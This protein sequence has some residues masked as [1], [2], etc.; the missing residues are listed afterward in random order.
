MD[1][2]QEQSRGALGSDCHGKQRRQQ[3]K[4]FFNKSD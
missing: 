3:K 1:E 4:T 2:N